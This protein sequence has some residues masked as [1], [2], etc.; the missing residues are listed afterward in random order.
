[1]G[2]TLNNLSTPWRKFYYALDVHLKYFG[3][4]CVTSLRDKKAIF[5]RL[6]GN[7][8]Q[9][10]RHGAVLSVTDDLWDAGDDILLNGE[11]RH[12][13]HLQHLIGHLLNRE[14]KKKT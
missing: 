1:M 9:L 14:G 8:L 4:S 11:G 12:A 3:T 13:H 2:L 6:F 5:Q 10:C 7:S